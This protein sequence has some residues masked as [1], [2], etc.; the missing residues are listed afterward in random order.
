L[1][2]TF[3]WGISWNREADIQ[4]IVQLV[5]DLEIFMKLQDYSASPSMPGEGNTR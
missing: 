4:P 5:A 3:A 1:R 2:K